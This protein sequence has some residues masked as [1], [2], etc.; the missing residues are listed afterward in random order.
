MAEKDDEN[1]IGFDPLAWMHD[2][3]ASEV[4]SP[5]D[6]SEAEMASILTEWRESPEASGDEVMAIESAEN[7][8]L[9]DDPC[10]IALEATQSIQNIQP[11][12]EALLSAFSKGNSIDVDASAIQQIDTASLQLLLIA[13]QSAG[14][15]QKKLSIDFPSERFIEAAGLL[16]LAEILEVDSAASGFF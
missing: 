13:K 8:G 12:H 10:H 2:T 1:L 14:K 9:A 4:T 16:G 15:L 3:A 6:V 11:L 5:S 7:P